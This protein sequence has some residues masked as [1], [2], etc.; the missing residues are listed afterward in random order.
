MSTEIFVS[1]LSTCVS[2]WSD[3][4]YT[5]TESS[6][7][8][9]GVS[10]NAPYSNYDRFTL[11]VDVDIG[12]KLYVVYYEYNTGDSFSNHDGLGEIVWVFKD[13]SLAEACKEHI[14]NNKEEPSF[15]FVD[16]AGNS[17]KIGNVAYGYFEN[18]DCVS[19]DEFTIKK[20]KTRK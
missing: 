4:D 10:T 6:F 8:I 16:E 20:I 15:V 9:T 19:I 13:L 17:I 7:E 11:C 2:E 12:D 14:V 1:Y 3:D 18:I 5:K